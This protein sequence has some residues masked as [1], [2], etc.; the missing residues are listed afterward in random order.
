MPGEAGVGQA[1]MLAGF[2]ADIGNQQDFRKSGEQVLLDDMNFQFSEARAEL[3]M[4]LV[5]QLLVAKHDDDVVVEDALDLA[6]C[7]VIDVLREIEADF[8]A[9]G[10][11]AFLHRWPHRA[12]LH[13]RA[14]PQRHRPYP[15]KSLPFLKACEVRCPHHGWVTSRPADGAY[16]VDRARSSNSRI[17]RGYPDRVRP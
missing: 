4:P 17:H 15:H 6:E 13:R 11:A 7:P 10:R 5:R 1:D 14:L 12:L 16:S 9:A 2:V 8:R 3:D